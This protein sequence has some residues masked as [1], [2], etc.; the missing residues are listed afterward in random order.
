MRVAAAR[1]RIATVAPLAERIMLAGVAGD[2]GPANAHAAA[3]D[4][5]AATAATSASPSSPAKSPLQKNDYSGN[6][7]EDDD[8]VDEIELEA[9]DDSFVSSAPVS[10]SRK[11][12][13]VER[14]IAD[15]ERQDKSLAALRNNQDQQGGDASPVAS[16]TPNRSPKAEKDG[17]VDEYGEDFEEDGEGAG[18]GADFE[19]ESVASEVEDIE[20]MSVGG[21]DDDDD[22]W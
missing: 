2:G 13:E 17:S 9:G 11:L 22:K 7:F 20:E 21:E 5:P 10:P 12:S 15:M 14:K 3:S 8:E 1:S 4:L 18:T 19:V 16:S 6:S